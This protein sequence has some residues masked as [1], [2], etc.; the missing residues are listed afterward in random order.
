MGQCED[1]Y[2]EMQIRSGQMESHDLSHDGHGARVQARV[3]KPTMERGPL[4]LAR[5]VGL[6]C[7]YS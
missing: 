4:T 3:N 7:P 1:Q 5:W 2:V 6:Q